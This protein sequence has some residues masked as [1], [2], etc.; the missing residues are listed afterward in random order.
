PPGPLTSVAGGTADRPPRGLPPPARRGRRGRGARRPDP[1]RPGGGEQR[2]SALPG[3][4]QPPQ[5][6]SAERDPNRGAHL[7]PP[8]GHG[9][10]ILKTA[11]SAPNSRTRPRRTMSEPMR[12]GDPTPVP[13]GQKPRFQ[14]GELLIEKGLITDAQLAEALVERRQ[15]GG[16]L[17][18][19]LVRLRFAFYRHI[20]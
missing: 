18:E 5:G 3:L 9:S 16:L 2:D 14:L 17:G 4:R 12:P 19:T 10:I 11:D 13:L 7:A 6:R 15:H 1:R 8:A 20:G